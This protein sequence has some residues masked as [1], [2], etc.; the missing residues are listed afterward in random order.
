MAVG[1]L[2]MLGTDR[3]LSLD[4]RSAG[5]AHHPGRRVAERAV[6][7]MREWGQDISADY[8]KPVTDA[9]VAWADLILA[10]AQHHAGDL[11][12]QF[13]SAASKVRALEEDVDDPYCQPID[14]YRE[15]RN[16]L[17]ELLAR[18]V[19]QLPSD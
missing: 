7:V 18:V 4:V 11:A 5:I 9:D 2:R 1:L 15:C 6:S 17:Q 19:G 16:Q 14:R 12:D 8:S 13:P 10:V 3:G